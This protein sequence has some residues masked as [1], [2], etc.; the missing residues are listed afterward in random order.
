MLHEEKVEFFRH[1]LG[2]EERARVMAALD[3]TILTTGDFV[4]E[5]ERALADYLD[6]AE[7]VC[8]DSCTG[9][10][11]LA[12]LAADIGPGDEVIVP[13]MTFVATANAVMMAGA[14][15]VFADVEADTGCMSVA[16]IEPKL[17]PRT[18]AIIPVHL[19]G[20]LC[21]MKSISQ[22]ASERRLRIIEDSAHCL[23]ANRDGVRPASHS[24][25][26]CFSFYATKAM[27]CGEGGALA[28]NDLKLANRVRRLS[29]HGMTS[30]AADRYR[31]PYKH[32]DVE[33]LGWKYNLDNIRGSLLLP[34]IKRLDEHCDRRREICK[35]YE[36]A[37]RDLPGVQLPCV[38]D[39]SWSARHLF[40][41]W[42][43]PN[44]RDEFM[45][46]LEQR[47]IGA[48]VNYRA[49]H[50]LSLYATEFGYQPGDLPVAES[51]GERT[52]SLPLYPQMTN[53]QVDRVIEVVTEVLA[54]FQATPK[55]HATAA[56]HV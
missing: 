1:A 32:W 18:R 28:T 35:R 53:G 21:D 29:L 19:Y 36:D 46:Q 48:V 2:E 14:T 52:V 17:T 3:G 39:E 54:S 4:A 47:E 10:L 55:A 8:L 9:A 11:H 37:F 31:K 30:S 16:T 13:A 56:A 33:E 43:P 45:D 34:Q 23:E 27:T 20:L 6:V 24:L 49:V 40:T 12:L 22:L 5:A 44:T 26:A 7:V 41:L 15:P 25:A 51:M 42:V 38:L 50:L